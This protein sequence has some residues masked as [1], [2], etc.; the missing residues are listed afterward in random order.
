MCSTICAQNVQMGK[1]P[2]LIAAKQH[3]NLVYILMKAVGFLILLKDLYSK[4]LYFKLLKLSLRKFS[5]SA[6]CV[7]LQSNKYNDICT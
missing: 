6:R 7:T 5:T 4:T 2:N 1:L 3:D